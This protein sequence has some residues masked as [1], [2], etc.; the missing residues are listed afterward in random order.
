A[1]HL[2]IER[3]ANSRFTS[4]AVTI[5]VNPALRTDTDTDTDTDTSVVPHTTYY[6]RVRADNNVSTSPWSNVAL[7]PSWAWFT[8]QHTPPP[9]R[10]TPWPAVNPPGSRKTRR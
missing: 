10:T 9:S 1:T 3:A 2:Q 7:V 5:A 6:Y 4:H 8:I